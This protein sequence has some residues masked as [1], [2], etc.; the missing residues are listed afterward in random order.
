MRFNAGIAVANGLDK[1]EALAAI[2]ANVAEVFGMNAGQI[3][4]GKKA[5]LVL[6]NDDPF[7]LSASVEKL[8]ISGTET[9]TQSRQDKLRNR[10]MSQSELPK[11]YIK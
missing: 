1:Q 8:W 4:E 5:D 7:E 11:A 6:W 10:Y 3:A 9:T 2:T